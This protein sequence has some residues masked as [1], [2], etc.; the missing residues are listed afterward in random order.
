MRGCQTPGRLGPEEDASF[1]DVLRSALRLRGKLDVVVSHQCQLLKKL[2]TADFDAV[3]A[4]DTAEIAGLIDQILG[5]ESDLLSQTSKLESKVRA[6][7]NAPFIKWW[8]APLNTLADQMA[9]LSSIAESLHLDS[10]DRTS[11][12]LGIAVSEFVGTR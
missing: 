9:H 10:D 12:L 5:D 3:P 11:A 1:L 7:W 2:G 6:W 8:R 4:R